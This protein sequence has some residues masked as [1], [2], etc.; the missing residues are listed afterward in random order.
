MRKGIVL[1]GGRGTRL[2]P[3]TDI[4]SKQLL[5]V[6]DKPMIYYAL[7]V[8]MIGGIRE[9]L[10]VASPSD[11][12]RFE[13]LLGDGSAYGLSLSYACQKE[14]RGLP[15]AFL[16]GEDFIGDDPVALILG[17][18]IFYGVGLSTVLER[19][20]QRASGATLFTYEMLD[21]RAFGV[22]TLDA[23]GRPT[24]I[25][26]KPDEP[27]SNLV[28]TGLYYYESRVADEVKT[29]KP[30]ARGELEITDLNNIYLERGVIEVERL[31][32]GFAWMD[33]GTVDSLLDASNF[34]ATVER[35]QG[36]KIA[37]LEEI[38]WRRGWIDI[39]ELNERAAQYE[40]SAYATYLR[41]LVAGGKGAHLGF[42]P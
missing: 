41:N 39:D 21:P 24:E 31:G 19:A 35:R 15:D 36:M 29:L 28:V 7:S 12:P 3:L 40:P 5:P 14:P 2:R 1:A 22:V 20:G 9:V 37:C 6:Y 26:E 30:S 27:K 23:S 38:A 33:A 25:V 32:R 13:A 34:I 18:N 8:L 10:I 4:V 16:I 42:G 17:D 11:L